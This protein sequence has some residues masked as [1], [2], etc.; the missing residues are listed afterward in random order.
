MIKETLSKIESAISK[1]QAGD[2]KEKA[3]LI[4]LLSK[5]KAELSAL[6][7]SRIDD[8]RSIAHF[9]ETAAHEATRANKSLERKNLS[10]SGIAY[11]VKGFEASHPQLVEITNEICMIL[12]R[13]GI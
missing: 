7:E 1:I 12:A 4:S 11:S 2:G 5:L 3:E 6:P 8:A 9:T 10:I 13:M